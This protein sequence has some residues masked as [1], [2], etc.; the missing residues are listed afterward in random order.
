MALA[1]AVL[2]SAVLA[3]MFS[4][5]AAVGLLLLSGGMCAATIASALLAASR[6]ARA[7]QW[8]PSEWRNARWLIAFLHLAQ[9]FARAWGRLK[10][11]WTLRDER[12]DYP[13][14]NHVY[15]NLSQRDAWLRHLEEHL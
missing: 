12:I 11:W 6:A 1:G 2:A 9:P 15:G 8:R 13:A 7:K 10:G 14:A 3:L 5:W 4:P